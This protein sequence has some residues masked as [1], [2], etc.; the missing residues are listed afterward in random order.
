MRSQRNAFTL[1]ELLVVV[2]ILAVAAGMIVPRLGGAT[3]RQSL[4]A[5]AA[6]LAETARTV[7]EVAVS[8]RALWAIEL[9]LERGYR[10]LRASPDDPTGQ[11]EPVQGAWLKAGKWPGSVRVESFRTPEGKRF[12]RGTHRLLFHPDG[13]SSGGILQLV[14][15]SEPD[16]V[17]VVAI[18]PHSGRVIHGNP[19]TTDFRSDRVELGE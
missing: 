19:R 13:S 12:T 7:R 9:D 18:Q 5:T 17:H 10:I 15:A 16:D 14:S 2:A 6:R 11:L 8:R 4:R 1:I 3:G